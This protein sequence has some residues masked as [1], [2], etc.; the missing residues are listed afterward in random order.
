MD[1]PNLCTLLSVRE[2]RR[3]KYIL[4]CERS[5][6]VD[7]YYTVETMTRQFPCPFFFLNIFFFTFILIDQ[8]VLPFSS[9]PNVI[10]LE[11]SEIFGLFSL[12]LKLIDGSLTNKYVLYFSS[13]LK[14]K[15][16]QSK[17][18]SPT[19]KSFTSMICIMSSRGRMVV[20]QSSTVVRVLTSW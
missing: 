14:L 9:L 13:P 10:G 17:F 7:F 3:Y 20:G 16:E 19:V 6:R 8:S 12:Y 11:V 5:Y 4:V 18:V 1:F 15:E 2:R